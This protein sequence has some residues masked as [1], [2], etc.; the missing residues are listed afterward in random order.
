MIPSPPWDKLAHLAAFGGFAALSWVVFKGTSQAG[1]IAVV[2]LISLMDEGM[3][4][5][6]PGRSADFRDIVADLTGAV[7]AI[8]VLKFL[9]TMASRRRAFSLSR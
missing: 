5:Y 6:S 8:L 4:Y 2:A 3:Q 1:P 9:Q 7:L